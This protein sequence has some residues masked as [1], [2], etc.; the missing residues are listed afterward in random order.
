ML[1]GLHHH[2]AAPGTFCFFCLSDEMVRHARAGGSRVRR[3]TC[4]GY[5]RST[6]V[7]HRQRGGD[8]IVA[9]APD[10]RFWMIARSISRCHFTFLVC[11]FLCHWRGAWPFAVL[12]GVNLAIAR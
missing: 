5:V 2:V 6:P 3:S 8:L 11:L 1:R 7:H 9:L 4:R 12:A 10:G